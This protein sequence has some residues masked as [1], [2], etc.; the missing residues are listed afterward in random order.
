MIP[1]VAANSSDIPP[2]NH[3]VRV[4]ASAR[5]ASHNA[6]NRII[7]PATPTTSDGSSRRTLHEMAS[8]DTPANIRKPH[9]LSRTT[10]MGEEPDHSM[11]PPAE[12][13]PCHDITAL[14]HRSAVPA[15]SQRPA[16]GKGPAATPDPGAQPCAAPPPSGQPPHPATTTSPSR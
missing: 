1:P 6:P 4:P 9:M 15:D 3:H 11:R 12:G 16:P 10:D 14:G 5:T 13:C 7:G 8:H 2:F